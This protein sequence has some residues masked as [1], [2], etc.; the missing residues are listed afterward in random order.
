MKNLK[1]IVN[2]LRTYE[3]EKEWF[4]FKVDWYE[5]KELGEYISALSNSAAIEGREEA[6]FV[7]G[8]DNGTHDVVGTKFN[9]DIDVKNEPLKHF[10]ARKTTPDI[11]FTFE[12]IEL[13]FSQYRPQR[14]FLLPLKKSALFV[15]VQVRKGWISIQ[16][17]RLICLMS[18]NMDCPLL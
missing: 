10:L 17:G 15:L 2:E 5:P 12:G 1:K 3:A 4:E 7:W 14:E 6:Y 16:R 18:S 13:F 8:I 9:Y 11:N